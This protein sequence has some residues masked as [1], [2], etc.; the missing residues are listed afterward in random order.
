MNSQRYS[1]GKKVRSQKQKNDMRMDCL[2]RRIACGLAAG[3][4]L[5]AGVVEI[6]RPVGLAV[7]PAGL[8]VQ[9]VRPGEVYSIYEVSKT[10]LT[11]YNRD[12]KPHT[13]LLSTHKPSTVGNKKW[14]KGY[15]EIPN[16]N[17]CWFEKEELKVEANGRGLAKIYLGVPDEEKYYNQHWVVTLGVMGKPKAGLG[18]A[19]GVYVRL[20]IETKS[21]A[22]TEG[23]PDG[24]I[25][26]KPSTV[27]FENVPLGHTQESKVV[28]FNNDNETHSYRITSLLH[29]KEIKPKTYLTYSYQMIPDPE[30]IVLDRNRL[31]IMPGETR[32]LSLMLKVPD[33]QKYYGK[34][35]EEILLVEPNEGIPGFIRIKIE[36][37][38]TEVD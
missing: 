1:K 26:F 8:L 35:W 14:E 36:T 17:W 18:V 6:S 28:I 37:R 13:Y 20:Q 24:I 15:L 34:K 3:V 19:L 10:G 32:S 29:N 30:W 25:A 33:E 22:D 11:I 4:M 5:L 38:K 31:G 12:D 7:S 23:I 9:E 16:P 21:K 2:K 27:R